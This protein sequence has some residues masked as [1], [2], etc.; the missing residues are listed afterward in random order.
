VCLHHLLD[1]VLV[2]GL[3][4][5]DQCLLVNLKFILVKVSSLL[6]LFQCDF[7]FLLAFN[8]VSFI[9]FFL[10]L[11]ELA[12]AFPEGFVSI[13]G[14][15]H[16]REVSLHVLDLRF[17]LYDIFRMGRTIEVGSSS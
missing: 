10:S 2:F 8:E 4:Y 1:L 5:F 13:I 17:E 6:Q 11:E 7:K 16:I 12:F 15:L 3:N 9:C 14:A